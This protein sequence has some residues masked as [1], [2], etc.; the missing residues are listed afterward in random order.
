M[1]CIVLGRRKPHQNRQV[2]AKT[3]KGNNVHRVIYTVLNE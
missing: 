3:E 2:R 1:A